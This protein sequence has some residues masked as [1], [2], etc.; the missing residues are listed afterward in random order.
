MSV[1]PSQNTRTS[2]ERKQIT[3]RALPVV[4]WSALHLVTSDRCASLLNFSRRL[5]ASGF[6]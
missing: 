1:T 5:R 6:F 3:G 2:G 4:S